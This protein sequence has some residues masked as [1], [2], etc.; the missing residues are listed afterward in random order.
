MNMFIQASTG[1]NLG[2]QVDKVLIEAI[3]DKNKSI[4]CKI[5]DGQILKE[6]KSFKFTIQATDKSDGGSTVKTIIEYENLND[7]AP[8][9][10]NYFE[11]ADVLYKNIDA[12]LIN[13]A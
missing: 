4:S 8:P 1:G 2:G 9:P 3:D 7:D 12:Y 13:S 5:V 6:Y 11:F 10:N